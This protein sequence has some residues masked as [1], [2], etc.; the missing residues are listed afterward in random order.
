MLEALKVIVLGIVEGITEWLPIS[1][2]GH[3]ILV[4]EFI[5][6]KMTED[7]MSMFNVVIQL[8]AILAVV[9]IYFHKLNPFSNTKTQKQKMLTLQLWVKVLI[10]SVPAAIIGLLFDDFIDAHLMNYVVVAITLILY[11]I[12]FIV[13]EKRHEHVKPAVKRL[14]DLTIPMVVIIGCFQVLALIPGTSRSG[15]TIIGGLLIGAA[16]GVA[17][18]FTFFLAIP[19]MFGASFLKIIKFGFHFTGAEVFLL[20]LGCIISFVVSIF[21]IKFLMQYIKNHDFKVFGYYRIVLG[22]I[23]LL[24]FG[25]TALFA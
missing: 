3:L 13:V 8:G 5:K 15:A 14:S 22:I 2:T 11:G 9:V 12:A 20:L 25:M 21:A 6:L 10:A 1:S 4:E 24:Y 16:R 7:F 18:E 17:A 23:V 19:V